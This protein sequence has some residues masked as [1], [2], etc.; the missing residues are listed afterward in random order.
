MKTP[1]L[2]PLSFQSSAT[3]SPL[4]GRSFVPP[5]PIAT[6]PHPRPLP[7]L[8]R[9]A[10]RYLWREWL[11]PLALPLVLIASAKSALADINFVPTG[12]MQPTILP[13]DVVFI[14]KL[15]YDLRVPFTTTRLAQW[16]DPA[17][18]DVVVCFSPAD[19]VR[20]VKRIVALPGDTVELRHDVLYVNGVRR[21]YAPLPSTLA[22]NL[23]AID[24]PHATLA[25]E[26]DPL[27]R[28]GH[29][30]M[31]LPSTPA[32]RSFG[33]LRVTDGH[34]FA[35]GDNRNNS[36]DSRFFG[37]IPREQIIGRARGVFVSADLDRWL[38][39][40]LDRTFTALE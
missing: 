14:N 27:S 3:S 26:S 1:R 11:R 35:L 6:A 18:D 31:F 28:H 21:D 24:R 37:P 34:Y 38:K 5:H 23:P 39:P 33:P 15:A 9:R 40:R 10:A 7:S 17:R 16:S 36:H 12:S 29:A 20:L 30:V 22:H 25:R 32:L 13:G 19:G 2:T 4:A 8:P